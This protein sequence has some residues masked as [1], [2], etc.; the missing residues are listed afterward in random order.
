LKG[1]L[2]TSSGV[3]STYLLSAATGYIISFL[4]RI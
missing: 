2:I 1:I 3:N 4:F